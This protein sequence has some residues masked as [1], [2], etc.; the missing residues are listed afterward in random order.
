MTSCLVIDCRKGNI[1]IIERFLGE[2]GQKPTHLAKIF[3]IINQKIPKQDYLYFTSISEVYNHVNNKEKD[4]SFVYYA[5]INSLD[6]IKSYLTQRKHSQNIIKN[7]EKEKPIDY[8]KKI[9][10]RITIKNKKLV[11][12]LN[13]A[14][15]W[16]QY[17]TWRLIMLYKK[18][19]L[20]VCSSDEDEKSIRIVKFSQKHQFLESKSFVEYDKL[21]IEYVNRDFDNDVTFW[22]V[23]RMILGK[24]PSKWTILKMFL[25]VWLLC[26]QSHGV[27]NA[28]A[29]NNSIS[30][31]LLFSI[32]LATFVSEKSWLRFIFFVPSPFILYALVHFKIQVFVSMLFI[33]FPYL[34]PVALLWLIIVVR[35]IGFFNRIILA[36]CRPIRSL[37]LFF[38][39]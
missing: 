23:I 17:S 21:K 1:K 7:E 37:L 22:N 28:Q 15:S 39:K 3:Y 16:F 33:I 20:F 29:Y 6:N 35:L 11:F 32:K 24:N 27:K 36:V 25:F 19:R 9:V 13:L 31:L 12:P 14:S 5:S 26:L 4:I 38:K 10:E 18:V 34:D 2:L 30:V 8:R